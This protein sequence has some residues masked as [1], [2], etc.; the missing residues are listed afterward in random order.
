M[1]IPLFPPSCHWRHNSSRAFCFDGVIFFLFF[2]FLLFFIFPTIACVY[3]MAMALAII[4]R[5]GGILYTRANVYRRTHE[6]RRAALNIIV[7]YAVYVMYKRGR[8]ETRWWVVCKWD[9]GA[10][11]VRHWCVRGYLL[12]LTI[13][14]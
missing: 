12:I 5:V 9:A 3:F 7:V 14:W 11:L 8:G 6:M 4:G 2:F 13:Y 1:Y 10:P